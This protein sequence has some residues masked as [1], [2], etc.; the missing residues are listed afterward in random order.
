VTGADQRAALLFGEA[1]ALEWLEDAPQLGEEGFGLFNGTHGVEGS[2]RV[3]ICHEESIC[4]RY[5][6]I[7]NEALLN[8]NVYDVDTSWLLVSVHESGEIK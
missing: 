2:L 4:Y 7:N 8:I 5:V 6:V 1:F 3:R